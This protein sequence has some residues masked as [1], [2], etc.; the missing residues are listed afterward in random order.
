VRAC[1]SLLRVYVRRVGSARNADQVQKS[2]ASL[3]RACS[4]ERV[5]LVPP[6]GDTRSTASAA[7]NA[8]AATSTAKKDRGL[9]SA[10]AFGD[11]SKS[12][13]VS[14]PPGAPRSCDNDDD[15]DIV[16]RVDSGNEVELHCWPR[17]GSARLSWMTAVAAALWPTRA[18]G[19]H[20]TRGLR[21]S[22]AALVHFGPRADCAA[23]VIR[24]RCIVRLHR[25]SGRSC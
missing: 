12:L 22:N 18:D 11:T 25:L 24:A 21:V 8:Q 19:R 7:V 15:V 14:T 13:S 20:N 5:S 1:K 6:C 2:N 10:G 9:P 16:E 3:T 17:N 23:E 4:N